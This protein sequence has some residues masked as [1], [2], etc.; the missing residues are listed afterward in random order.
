MKRR[1]EQLEMFHSERAQ[2]EVITLPVSVWGRLVWGELADAFADLIL[3][4]P[5][6]EDRWWRG[7]DHQIGQEMRKLGL[8]PS[9]VSVEVKKARQYVANRV[10]TKR[11]AYMRSAR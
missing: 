8:E 9:E 10:A 7:I 5:E 11:G 2:A 3:S 6:D 1:P 4:R